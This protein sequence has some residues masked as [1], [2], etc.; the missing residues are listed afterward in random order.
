M[1][2]ALC[3]VRQPCLAVGGQGFPSEESSPGYSD[4]GDCCCKAIVASFAIV[5]KAIVTEIWSAVNT[6]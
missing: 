6:V 2:V 4:N 5:A 3:V 1:L